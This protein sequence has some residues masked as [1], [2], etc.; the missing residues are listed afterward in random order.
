M[1]KNLEKWIT[2]KKCDN[3]NFNI[4][5]IDFNIST[6]DNSMLYNF[7]KVTELEKTKKSDIKQLMLDKIFE[8]CDH[9]NDEILKLF[10]YKLERKISSTIKNASLYIA[11]NGRIGEATNM[12][13]S[14]ENYDKYNISEFKEKYEILFEDINDII[15]YRKN[16][17]EEP[18]L[19][20]F[21]YTDENNID[22]YDIESIGFYPERQYIKIIMNMDQEIEQLLSK[23]TKDMY[24]KYGKIRSVASKTENGN[25][26][27]IIVDF[28]DK[29]TYLSEDDLIIELKKLLSYFN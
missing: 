23:I 28:D 15:L 16:T 9:N 24:I 10:S 12:I 20:L 27:Y 29:H 13:I 17:F 5:F 1:D 6:K 3:K 11:A 14:K 25:K 22:Y 26:T 18:G 8:L 21:Y 2:L 4:C 19:V 7:T